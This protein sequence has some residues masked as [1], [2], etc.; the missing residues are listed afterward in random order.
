M[1][2]CTVPHA[3]QE[4]CELLDIRMVEIRHR[5]Q[6]GRLQALGFRC[7]A[8]CSLCVGAWRGIV[9]GLQMVAGTDLTKLA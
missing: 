9:T 5:W 7:G 8:G 3:L 2:Y 6:E 1:S 4:L